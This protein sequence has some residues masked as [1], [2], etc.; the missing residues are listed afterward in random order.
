MAPRPRA[1]DGFSLPEILLTIAIVGI[2]FAAILGGMATSIVVSDVHRKQATTDALA[3]S[4]AE[5]VKDHA[6]AYVDCAGP[7]A[8]A[9]AL[10]QA[11]AG[12]AVEIQQVRYW[13]GPTATAGAPYTPAFQASCPSPDRGMQ[14]ITIVASSGD[15]R[16]TE[17]VEFIKRRVP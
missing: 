9:S 10:P 2:A 15:G 16:A 1:E 7:N 12:Y 6:V 3:R 17:T 4:A 8:Y 5:A 13:N 14:L 11:P